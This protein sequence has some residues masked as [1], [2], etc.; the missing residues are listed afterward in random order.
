MMWWRLTIYF[1]SATLCDPL[2]YAISFQTSSHGATSSVCAICAYCRSKN[3]FLRCL[4][5][6]I[7]CNLIPLGLHNAKFVV[8]VSP[9]ACLLDYANC[10]SVPQRTGNQIASKGGIAMCTL[11]S[12][13]LQLQEQRPGFVLALKD[14]SKV[15]RTIRNC[16]KACHC[17]QTRVLCCYEFSQITMLHFLIVRLFYCPVLS[18]E[19]CVSHPKHGYRSLV[20]SYER[21]GCFNGSIHSKPL[22][23]AHG[24]LSPSK[25]PGFIHSV[26]VCHSRYQSNLSMRCR[27]AA[28]L[29]LV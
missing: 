23:A 13:A 4:I 3:A 1:L 7:G 6:T 22:D 18:R 28:E 25:T 24:Y 17:R 27:I 20:R 10:W 12:M 26:Q 19:A 5:R 8:V 14:R 2:S 15:E 11:M 21:F 29:R 9:P 16:R